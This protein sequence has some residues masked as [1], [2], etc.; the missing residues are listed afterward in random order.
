MV[1]ELRTGPD[2]DIDAV[3]QYL[4]VARQHHTQAEIAKF[5]DVDVKNHPPLGSS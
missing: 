3:F 5:L 4:A 2:M 1:T